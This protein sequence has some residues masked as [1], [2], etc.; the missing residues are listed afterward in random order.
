MKANMLKILLVCVGFTL[1][2]HNLLLA[3]DKLTPA[4]ILA[5]FDL[6]KQA[7]KEAHPG[8]Y[9]YNTRE[10]IDSIFL[11][12]ERQ[13]NHELSQQEFYRIL[14]PAISQLKCGHTKLHPNDNWSDYFFFGKDKVFPLRLFFDN[15]TAYV[16]G[17]YDHSLQVP[18]GKEIVSIN[19]KSV[20]EIIDVLLPAFLSDGNNKTFK[21]IEMNKFFSAYYANLIEA[22]DSFTIRLNDHGGLITLKV[23]AI[24]HSAIIAYEKQTALTQPARE[25]YSLKMVQ[26]KTALLT[27]SSFWMDSKDLSYKR[28]LKTAFA[29]IRD[30][31]IMQLII[32]V[33]DN[34]GGKDKRGAMLLSYLM[35]KKFSYYDRLEATTKKKFSFASQASSPRFYG[36]LRLLLSETDTGSYVWK[37]NKNLK[38]QKPRKNHFNG[39]VYVLTNGACFSVTSEFAAASHY[40]KRATFIGEETGGGYYGNNSGTFVIVTL[41]NSRLTIGIPMLAYYMAVK[42]YPYPDRGIMPDHKIRPGISDLISGRDP[43]LEYT[44][45][46]IN[47]R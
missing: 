13:L 26:D 47:K 38:I 23:P 17:S 18:V 34:E 14:L 3:Q 11:K 2:S 46:L 41:P 42:D 28:F 30:K 4:Q 40:L 45:N 44:L 36:I 9:R 39:K 22:P 16:L 10:Q 37:H 19:N 25:P 29:E 31:G 33:R 32:D 1:S 15:K 20:S 35:D 43:V 27:I 8:L 24:P 7:L 21:Y 5:D 6:F 12:T